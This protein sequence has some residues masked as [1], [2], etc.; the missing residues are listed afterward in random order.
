MTR[1]TSPAR[2][3]ARDADA[4]RTPLPAGRAFV[5]QLREDADPG[6]G[7]VTGRVEHVLSGSAAPFAS[8]PEL[9]AFMRD[10]VA[11]DASRER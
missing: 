1:T 5:V 3:A 11:R 4:T 6:S 8:L 9:V 10:A 7:T 2:S